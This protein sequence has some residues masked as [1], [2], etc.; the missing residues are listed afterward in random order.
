MRKIILEM[1][2]RELEQSSYVPGIEKLEMLQIIHL[3]KYTSRRYAGIC[4]VKLRPGYRPRDLVGVAGIRKVQPLS[5]EKSGAWLVY[6]EGRPRKEWVELASRS[7]GYLYPPFELTSERWRI[8]FIGSQSQVKKFLL[9]IDGIGLNYKMASA[10]DA[11]FVASEFL[12]PLTSKQR[13]VLSVAYARGFFDTPRKAGVRDL[14]TIL[15]LGKSAVVEHL[16]R[17]EKR[18]LDEI[19]LEQ[20]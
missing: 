12:S 14:A 18:I 20:Y 13:D 11:R 16:R 19:L 15:K 1:P 3:F 6:G 17:A 9:N 8:T 10:T 2:R 7:G 5:L 4:R